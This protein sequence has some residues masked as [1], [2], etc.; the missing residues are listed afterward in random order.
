MMFP[1]MIFSYESLVGSF[2]GVNHLDDAQINCNI[3]Q[4]INGRTQSWYPYILR[5]RQSAH[6]LYGNRHR[7]ISLEQLLLSK[8][9]NKSFT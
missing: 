3:C 5:N 9:I 2:C 1:D 8:Y 7:R 6:E 4:F